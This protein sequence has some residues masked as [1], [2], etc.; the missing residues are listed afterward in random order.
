MTPRSWLTSTLHRF[1]ICR[2]LGAIFALELFSLAGLL[3]FGGLALQSPAHSP[4]PSDL[5]VVLGGGSMSARLQKGAE[6][7]ERRLA[8]RI[9]VTGF[10]GESLAVVELQADWRYRYLQGIGVPAEAILTDTQARNSGEE[11]RAIA[12]LMQDKQWNTVLIVSDPPHLVRLAWILGKVLQPTNIRYQLIASNPTWWNA[13]MWWTNPVSATFVIE[14]Y[15]KIG[16]YLS[17]Y[18]S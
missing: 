2:F 7:Y 15:I 16:Y 9:L 1:H 4:E 6:L 10:S 3:A 13:T 12:Q 11:A 17:T 14:E 18:Q 5:I 8:S